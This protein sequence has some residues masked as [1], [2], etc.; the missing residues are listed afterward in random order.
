MQ[1]ERQPAG[2]AAAP[3]YGALF[4]SRETPG[5][6]IGAGGGVGGVF[7]CIVADPPWAVKAGPAQGGYTL[8]AD[9]KQVWDGVSRPS[10]ELEYPTMTVEEICALKVPVAKDAHLYLWTINA[11][12]EAS[13]RVARAWGFEP[14]TLLVWAKTPFGG[15]LGGTFGISTEFVLFCRRG[16]LRAKKR[17]TG[18]WWNWKRQYN[19]DGKPQHSAKPEAFQNMVESVSPGPYL[20]MFARRPR[21]NWTAWG[22]E[23]PSGPLGG[24]GRGVSVAPAAD[25]RHNVSSSAATPGGKDA[26]VR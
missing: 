9:G 18:T 15:G 10:R 2:F 4:D 16:S 17:V 5:S 26:D 24:G 25:E 19:A 21:P 13:Y 7:S 20:E 22:N 3:G 6:G 14:S 11:Y 12:V 1:T 8:N 23:I